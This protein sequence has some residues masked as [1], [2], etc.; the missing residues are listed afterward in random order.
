MEII[1]VYEVEPDLADEVEF[2]RLL[3]IQLQQILVERQLSK[4]GLTKPKQNYIETYG[5]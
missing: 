1:E 2:I 3:K 4:R 5:T